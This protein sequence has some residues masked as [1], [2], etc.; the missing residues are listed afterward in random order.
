MATSDGVGENTVYVDQLLI[1]SL[2]VCLQSAVTSCQ[3]MVPGQEPH[4]LNMYCARDAGGVHL[5]TLTTKCC[6]LNSCMQYKLLVC[7]QHESV[8]CIM[9]CAS[10]RSCIEL[11]L[12]ML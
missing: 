1:D 10:M 11:E 5:C 2:H 9:A 8:G 3:V 7:A 4:T 6:P 12:T